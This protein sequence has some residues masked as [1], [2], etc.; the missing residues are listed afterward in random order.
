MTSVSISEP[1]NNDLPQTSGRKPARLGE[2]STA[3][4]MTNAPSPQMAKRRSQAPGGY[5]GGLIRGCLEPPASRRG[6]G[7]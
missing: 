5:P 6:A 4:R 7:N 3:A 1:R 2:V